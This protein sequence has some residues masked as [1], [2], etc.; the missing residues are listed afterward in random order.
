MTVP[1]HRPQSIPA[2]MDPD[3]DI[4]R[5]FVD[6]PW[7]NRLATSSCRSI[8]KLMRYGPPMRSRANTL[9]WIAV[10]FFV[11]ALAA[12]TS[13]DAAPVADG[14]ATL[15]APGADPDTVAVTIKGKAKY[16]T[17]TT[18][19][20]SGSKCT[21]RFAWLPY[22]IHGDQNSFG[23]DDACPMGDL[24]AN[25]EGGNWIDVQWVGKEA[26][27]Q[28]A[29]WAPS[30]FVSDGEFYLHYAGVVKGTGQRCIWAVHA[31]TLNELKSAPRRLFACPGD[32][33]DIAIDP[34][35]FEHKGRL[36]VTYRDDG[37]PISAQESS[38]YVTEV[39]RHGVPIG[40]KQRLLHSA[41]L[42]WTHYAVWPGVFDQ[43]VENPSLVFDEANNDWL[44]FYSGNSYTYATYAT[45][46]ASC[47]PHLLGGPRCKPIG[48]N[49]RA[50][51]GFTGEAPATGLLPRYRMP[52]NLQGSAAVSIFKT[53][54]GG[55]A[56]VWH[57]WDRGAPQAPGAYGPAAIPGMEGQE[58]S[59]HASAVVLPDA[60]TAAEVRF[61][62]G[63][64]A[65]RKCRGEF[66]TVDLALGQSPTDGDDV[67]VGT[68]KDDVI[69]GGAGDDLI[70]GWGGADSIVGGPGNDTIYGGKGEDSMQGN[71]GDDI[72]VGGAGSDSMRGGRGS[73]TCRG[74]QGRDIYAECDI[75]LSAVEVK[76]SELTSSIEAS[77]RAPRVGT[78]EPD[79]VVSAGD[80]SEVGSAGL[81]EPT[82]RA[83]ANGITEES[84]ALD[85][86][87][88]AAGFVET[89]V[90]V[91]ASAG[92]DTSEGGSALPGAVDETETPVSI[93]LDSEIETIE[94]PTEPS[95]AASTG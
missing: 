88:F 13:A 80:E 58:R 60:K 15:G 18:S 37:G 32:P 29:L 33:G 70:C 21:S 20:G 90:T 5:G 50:F 22:Y 41:D 87:I 10:A 82:G 55:Y 77:D 95:V 7:R 85:A 72:I 12:P 36:F 26:D 4:L 52:G 75:A 63:A 92:S 94:T 68:A 78:N 39:N 8:A 34:D 44:L 38:I 51:I 49:N 35:M 30:I 40:E 16:V 27:R 65:A 23:L 84:D 89:D 42:P 57:A 73:D 54:Y 25:T 45:G 56:A 71:N 74:A 24:L 6:L 2:D 43:V 81:G 19:S 62:T 86:E 66:A 76:A 69:D 1:V 61:R 79:A 93:T 67:I 47:G 14:V 28:R 59:V 17:V 48:G 3:V 11:V 91:P 64:I 53:H 83:E 31:P 46:V 9:T